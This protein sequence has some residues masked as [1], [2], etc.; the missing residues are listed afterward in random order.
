[1]KAA[2]FY[3]KHDVRV[4]ERAIR[5]PNAEEVQI[6]VRAAGVCGTDLHI[7]E[8][9]KGATE[10]A[11]PVVL[12]HEFVGVV[13]KTGGKVFGYKPG[14]HVTVDPNISCNACYYCRN[15]KP[16]LCEYLA[17]TGVNY[18]GGFAEFCNV[19][20]KQVFLIP[21]EMPFNVAAMC[22]P[23]GCCL[24][25]IDLAHIKTGDTVMIIG[26]GPIGLI[27]MQLAAIA[28][29]VKIILME[30][31]AEKRE[32]A[33]KLG[34]DLVID[35]ATE[36]I[37]VFLERNAI[38]DIHVVIE[39]VG[40]KE[41]MMDAINFTGRGGTALLFGLTPPD[42]EIPFMPF[43]AFQKELNI[44][45][46]FTNQYTH[47]RAAEIIASGRLRLQE[48]ISDVFSLDEIQKAFD[49]EV[50]KGKIIIVP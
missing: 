38:W 48:L 5:E 36:D 4:E 18:D 29:A 9:A 34:A 20:Q 39:C 8:G 32:L 31:V 13:E 24:H 21:D 43:K 35:P 44:T 42:C 19:H 27:M 40:R 41:T 46:S 7:Y 15:G 16:H 22:E 17:A 49:M 11:P 10:C 6:R 37:K 14:D 33:K 3:G 47:A 30:P 45:A 25:G 23:V 12:G 2:V 28:G 26:G 1:V 50:R